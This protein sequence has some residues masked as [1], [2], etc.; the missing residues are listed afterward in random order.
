MRPLTGRE[1]LGEL[2]R[3]LGREVV[4]QLDQDELL[5]L[6]HGLPRDV[7][8]DQGLVVDPLDRLRL[9]DL[10]DRCRRPLADLR[11]DRARA[12]R[13][14]PSRS[15]RPP[16]PAACRPT[17]RS[18]ARA[19]SPSRGGLCSARA[20]CSAASTRPPGVCTTRSIGTVSGVSRI[21]RRT[22]SESSTSMKR[23]SGMPSRLIDS[24]RWISVMTREPRA[25][26]SLRIAR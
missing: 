14:R 9:G 6:L 25:V 1:L 16:A 13:S 26:S 2:V 21:A 19:P 20:I 23:R 18:A 11:V 10:D 22:C 24:C 4:E 15:R 5:D 7:R 8:E 12:P 17:S 3:A